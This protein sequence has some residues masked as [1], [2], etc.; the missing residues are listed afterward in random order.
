MLIDYDAI[1]RAAQNANKRFANRYPKG[2]IDFD[3][4]DFCSI[5]GL[6]IVP[7]NTSYSVRDFK[8][9]YSRHCQCDVAVINDKMEGRLRV[10]VVYHELGHKILHW[11]YIDISG[12]IDRNVFGVSGWMEVEANT[13]VAEVLLDDSEVLDLMFNSH[14]T[15]SEIA[16]ALRVPEDFLAFK[17]RSINHRLDKKI[18]IPHN[19]SGNCL[20]DLDNDDY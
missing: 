14:R 12:H 1:H 2:R 3:Y 5:N 9:R 11:R 8:A 10:I 6:K 17:Y 7:V 4:D 16:S 15:F 20:R 19:V 13:F 18:P